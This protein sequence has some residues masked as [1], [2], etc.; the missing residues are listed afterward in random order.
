MP[1]KTATSV[2]DHGKIA[3]IVEVQISV[4]P[5]GRSVALTTIATIDG[6]VHPFSKNLDEAEQ[7]A[8]KDLVLTFMSSKLYAGG[9]EE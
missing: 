4:V 7:R 5:R 6:K 8:V 9:L 2:I 1:K 3:A